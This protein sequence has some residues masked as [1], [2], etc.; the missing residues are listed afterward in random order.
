MFIK[1]TMLNGKTIFVNP[2]HVSAIGTDG[3]GDTSILLNG[4]ETVLSGS[5]DEVLAILSTASSRLDRFE[6]IAAESEGVAGYHCNGDLATWA[7][8]GL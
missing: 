1:L 5:L 8:L 3:D 6:A 4:I 7:E 2:D